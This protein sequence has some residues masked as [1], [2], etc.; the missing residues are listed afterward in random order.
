MQTAAIKNRFF[1]RRPWWVAPCSMCGGV[2]TMDSRITA[3]A[4]NFVERFGKQ[5]PA[6]AKRRI[7]ELRS[8]GN[9]DSAATWMQIYEE[10]KALVESGGAPPH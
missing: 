5:A 9:A 8:A 4:R 3:A 2:L 7:D 1:G 6:E 10:V